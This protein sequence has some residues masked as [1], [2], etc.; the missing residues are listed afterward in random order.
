M[1]SRNN[2]FSNRSQKGKIVVR[3]GAKS[4]EAE[5]ENEMQENFDKNVK[6]FKSEDEVSNGLEQ[7]GARDGDGAAKDADKK[8]VDGG[9]KDA[10]KKDV[11]GDTK[12]AD[13]K[14]IDGGATDAD[15]KNMDGGAK[16]ADKKDVDGGTKDSIEKVKDGA[17]R[18]EDTT[19]TSQKDGSDNQRIKKKD[20]EEKD[21]VSKKELDSGDV[22]DV[23]AELNELKG[24][25]VSYREKVFAEMD[26]DEEVESAANKIKDASKG[27]SAHPGAQVASSSSHNKVEKVAKFASSAK[28]VSFSAIIFHF[29]FR[30]ESGNTTKYAKLNLIAQSSPEK[31]S[32]NQ[33]N[34]VLTNR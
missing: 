12:D 13:K 26:K 15:T 32:F 14:D 23:E 4:D 18:E 25:A 6:D 1:C 27:S 21:A 17:K 8:N 22:S 28:Y 16:D 29:Y 10:D 31:F 11:D 3:G 33:K 7:D 19:S 24:H 20:G 9:A 34:L 30:Q 5:N 2:N